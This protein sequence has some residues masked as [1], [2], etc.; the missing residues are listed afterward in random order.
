MKRAKLEWKKAIDGWAAYADGRHWKIRKVTMG[1]RVL[2]WIYLDHSRF[3]PTGSYEDAVSRYSV[4]EAK[5]F[6][7]S[8]HRRLKGE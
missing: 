1:S 7:E 5:A 4:D 2:Y 6:V 8:E 3:T